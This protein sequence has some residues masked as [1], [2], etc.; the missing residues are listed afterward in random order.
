MKEKKEI[1]KSI[2]KWLVIIAIIILVYFWRRDLIDDAIYEMTEI[3]VSAG[4]LCL[5]MT[6]LYFATEGL[7]ISSMTVRE[8]KK[9]PWY[10]GFLSGLFCAFYRLITLGSGSGFAEIY[11]YNCNGIPVSKGTG[12]TL[13]QYTFQKIAIGIFGTAAFFYLYAAGQEGITD[14]AVYMVLGIIVITAIV[15]FLVLIAVSKKVADLIIKIAEKIMKEGSR[16]HSKLDTV[17]SNIIN[18]NKEGREIWSHKGH[19]VFIVLLNF[20][21]FI[22]WYSIPG[23]LLSQEFNVTIIQCIAVMAVVNMISCVMVTPSG[24]GT[25]EFMFVLLFGAVLPEENA[26]AAVI[27]YRFYTWI[28]P[29]IIGAFI[30]GF[31]K[32]KVNP[33]F[34]PD[35]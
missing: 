1:K 24:I 3:P 2:I 34:Q 9:L 18:F 5:V 33:D 7:I 27:L 17:K 12:M 35:T 31:H 29:F 19:F 8:E 4:I 32:R 22:C 14:Y 11:Y 13:V 10:K 26:T 20:V 6:L 23:I 25:L 21:K 16:F 15:F 28:V 30:A